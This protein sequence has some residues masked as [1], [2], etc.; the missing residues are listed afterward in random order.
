ME[1]N[2]PVD[3]KP[4]ALKSKTGAQGRDSAYRGTQRDLLPF[5]TSCPPWNLVSTL[6]IWTSLISKCKGYMSCIIPSRGL[7]WE[8][9]FPL[10]FK[11]LSPD[12]GISPIESVLVTPT[13]SWHGWV[14][15]KEQWERELSPWFQILS[16]IRFSPL[17]IAPT[18]LS[19]IGGLEY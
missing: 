5:F 3:L 2:S 9:I 18:L 7:T 4:V 10:K 1:I 13:V 16:V 12:P 8:P 14:E 15:R 19:A 17:P 6:L 11:L